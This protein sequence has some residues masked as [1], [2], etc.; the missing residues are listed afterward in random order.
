MIKT[1]NNVAKNPSMPNTVVDPTTGVI[2]VFTKNN[3]VV[4][5]IT[6]QQIVVQ[7]HTKRNIAVKIISMPHVANK[8]KMIKRTLV[9][10]N[11]N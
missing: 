11:I 4:P 10:N 9:M 6:T 2:L 1:K 5:E 3:N 7:S 8:I